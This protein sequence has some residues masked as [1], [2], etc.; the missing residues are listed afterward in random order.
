MQKNDESDTKQYIAMHPSRRDIL[1]NLAKSK[2]YASRLADE[3]KL[4]PK[5][6]QFHLSIL[7]KYGLVEGKFGL[8]TPPEGRPVA[9]KF[10]TL[11]KDGKDLIDFIARMKR[12]S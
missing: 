8:E 10:Y 12:P 1:L 7:E 6:V 3:L 9:V 5:V 2:T 11:A 4:N